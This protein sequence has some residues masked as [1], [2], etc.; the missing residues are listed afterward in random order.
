[1]DFNSTKHMNKRKVLQY[2][3]NKQGHSRSDIAK[4]L[5]ISKPTVSNIVDELLEEGWIRE[6]ESEKASSSG[7]RKPFR[8]S[9]NE[10]A[11]YI[12]GID[13]GGTSVEIAVLNLSGTIINKIAFDTQKH[14]SEN[15]VHTIAD[16]V[17]NL[18]RECGFEI[19]HVLGVGIGVPGITDVEN[20]IVVDA[21]TLNW[22]HTPLKSQ[23]ESLLKCPVYID[24]DVNVAALGEWWKGAGETNNNILMITLGTGIGCG[25]II[26]G[27]LYRGASY[28]AGEIGYMVTDKDAAH[29]K[30]DQTFAGYGFLD[31]HV[32]GPSITKRMLHYLGEKNNDSEN[33]SAERIF[34]MAIAGD[35]IALKVINEFLSHLSYALINVISIINPQ[36]VVLGGGI[37]KSMDSF[38]PYLSA[39]MKKHLPI[40]TEVSITTVEDVSL[41]GAGYLLLKEH[42][43]ILKV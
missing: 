31:N 35:E 36:Q 12:V 26:N 43:S 3:Q 23:L 11:S 10:N 22:K 13:I 27:D 25:L 39:T 28:A 9:F 17:N 18:L 5:K 34:Q 38:L 19:E 24:N 2:I 37:S 29:K 16:H 41:V 42:D 21:P 40:Q 7:G 33:W 6:K 8:I 4:A 15:F 1:M 30:Y 32:G 14:I 20:G